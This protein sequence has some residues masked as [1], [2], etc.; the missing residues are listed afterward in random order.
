[1]ADDPVSALDA[2]SPATRA[3]FSGAFRAP[4]AAQAGA[5]RAIAEETDALVVAPTG[6]GKTLAAF[7]ASLDRLAF[8]PPPAEAVK[9]CRVLYVSP[10]KALAVDVERNLRSPLTGIRQEAVR[11]GLPEPDIRV[12]IR[13]GDTPPAERR[14]LA[15]RP[16]DIL[17]TTPESL[18]LM[19]TSAAREAL[20]GVE[21]VILDEVHAVAG[22]KRGAHLALSL[23][24]LDEL[25]PR[26]ARRIGLSAT[27]RPVEEVARFLSPQRQARVVQPPAGK[28]FDLSV[29]VPVPDLGELGGSPV[30]DAPGAG[31]RP[32]IWPSVEERIAD[33]VQAHRSTIVFVNSRRLAERLC[34]RLNEIAYERATG[35][36]LPEGHGAAELMGGSGAGRGV[37]P[38]LA[39][40]H[41]GSVSKEQRAQVE[42]DL[43]AGR[44]PA[45]VATSSLELGID[46]GAVDLVVQVESP[47]SV[48]S[49][50]QRVG[51]AGHQVGAVSAGVVFPKYRGD[52]VQ[53]AVVTERMRQGAIESLRVPSNPLDVLAQQLVA[54][55]AMDTWDVDALLAVVRRAAP[56][57]ALPESAYHSVLDMLA[58]R[59]PSDA[60]AELRP[61]LVWDRVGHTVSGRPGAQRLAVT[62][63]GTIPDRGL[64]GVFLAGAD[65]R[66]GG[67]RVGELD[68][69]MVYESRVGDVFTLGTTSWRIED[70]TRDRVLVSPAPGVPARLP[71]WK[72]DQLGRPLELGRALGA[73]LREVGALDVASARRRLAG[74]GLDAWAVDNVLS[75][76]EEQRAACGHVPDDRTIVVE[77]FR[78]ELGDWRVVVHSPFGA[79]VHAPWALA[80]GARLAERFGID[81]QVLHADDGIVLRLPDTDPAAWDAEGPPGAGETADAAFDD[82]LA[83]VGTD[84]VLF[85]REEVSQLVTDQVGGSALFASRFRECAARALLLPRRDPGRRTPLWQQRQRAAQLLSVASEFGSFPIVLEAVRECLQDVFDVPGLAELM[86]DIEA[87][88]VRLVEVTTPEPSPFARSLLFGYVAQYLYEGDSPLAERRAAALSL[89]SRLLAELLGRAE[90]RELLDLDVLRELERELQWRTTERRL[91]DAEAVADALRVLGPLTDGELAERGADPRWAPGLADTRRALRVRIAG[92]E[93]W[94]AVEDA[95]RLR[96]ALGVA[97]PVGVPEA[98][99]EPVRDPLADLLARY[100]RTHGP[101]TSAQA[102]ARFGLGNAVADGVL[103]RMAAEGRL[104]QGEFHPEGIGQEWCDPAVLRRLR[105]RSLAVLREELEP[106]PPA[107]LAAFLPQWQHLGGRGVYSGALRGLDGLVRAVEQLQGAPVPASALEKLVLPSRVSGYGPTLLDELTAS[108]EVLWAGAGALPG[109]DGWVSLYLADAAPLLLPPARPLDITPVQQA[110]LDALR[111]GYGLF[112]R[113][114]ADQVRAAGHHSTDQSLADAVW[115][116][117]WTG[118]L[119]NDTLGPLRALLGSGRTKGATA[120]RAR[121]AVP[122]GRYGSPGAA[123]RRAPGAAPATVSGRWSLLPAPEP[124]ATLR[125]HALARTLL[126]RHGVVTRG[127]VAAEGVQGGFSAAYRVLSVFEESG[128]ARRGYVV[129]GLGA[130][131]FAMEGAVDRLRAVSGARERQD[132]G[133]GRRVAV[134]AAADPAHAYGA[135]LPWPESPDGAG[136]KP[137]RKAGAV[138]VLVEGT[139]VLYL[140]RGGRTL[141]AWPASGQEETGELWQAAAEA[142]A[143]AARAG[144]LGTLTVERVNG[145]PVLTAP[146]GQLLEAAGFHATPRGLRLRG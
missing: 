73:F 30:P 19:L 135:A 138:V 54:M 104:V 76:L 109:K 124:D 41:H 67:G 132:P 108:G 82:G 101:F 50:L 3:W 18:F 55:T 26:P 60:F 5:W 140:E 34:N 61:R 21:T 11:L 139:L 27:V 102:A 62:S 51:R 84:D 106:V 2:F 6:S 144:A 113:Q 24:R 63:G 142:L 99:T 77:R 120:H 86:G 28:E 39:R 103:R 92:E 111:G 114:I 98:F 22:T 100:A 49:G 96:D 65:P 129:E 85:A 25:L 44:L 118:R 128:Q 69:E 58:G 4:T 119:T 38:V 91:K 81:A 127:A 9:R 45:V 136:H 145:S 90:L 14:A 48:A 117:A 70:I 107:A 123:G 95:G 88:R 78:D 134:L 133:A 75:Y 36:P 66:K 110:V 79:Q 146:F 131:Q 13:S 42:E 87:R 47:P 10:L 57:A 29:V 20:S 83:P 37:P 141:L 71:F 93:H 115:E 17:I 126:D 32:S 31:E 122:R 125:A 64:F 33:L 80:L 59:Y 15:R 112:F 23:E 68:E 56:F 1:M 97:L 94:A 116:L 8:R 105:R 40:A 46:M 16:P 130:A 74:A 72:G 43:K 143:E 35:E 89:D 121:R 137:G 53:S 52:L 7:L 12:G